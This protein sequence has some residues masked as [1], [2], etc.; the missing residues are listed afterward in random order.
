MRQMFRTF[1]PSTKNWCSSWPTPAGM[2]IPIRIRGNGPPA[3]GRRFV[4]R[5]LVGDFD[6]IWPFCDFRNGPCWMSTLES[7]CLTSIAI[8]AFAKISSGSCVRRKSEHFHTFFRTKLMNFNFPALP[9][10]K[11][12][13]PRWRRVT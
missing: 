7:R 3:I 13:T 2:R 8:P 9:P 6:L 1:R 5:K 12:S 10:F 4:L 11:R